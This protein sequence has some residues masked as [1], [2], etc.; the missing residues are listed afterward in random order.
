MNPSQFTIGKKI[1]LGFAALIALLAVVAGVSRYALAV[2]S[3]KFQLFSA[4]AAESHAAVSLETAMTAVKVQVN[5]FL[6]S[7]SPESIVAYSTAQKSLQD[8]ITQAEKVIVEPARARQI[9][10]AKELLGRYHRAFEALMENHARRTQLEETI[11]APKG[12]FVKDTLQELM[13]DARNQ[14]DM[15]AAFRIA[16]ALRAFFECGTQVSSFLSTSRPEMAT[17]ARASLAFVGKQIELLQQDQA[18]MEKLDA[19]LKDEAKT[20]RLAAL[21]AATAAYSSGL[22]QIVA[23]K[24]ARDELVRDG[25]N[26]IAPEFTA[27]IAQVSRSLHGYQQEIEEGVRA[28]QRRNELL[29]FGITLVGIVTGIGAGW[30]VVR[31]ATVPIRKIAVVLAGD[32]D[33]TKLAAASVAEAAH[34]MA[35]G[36]SQQAASLEESS[37]ALQE[38]SSM[39]N[40][41]S[42]SAQSA[43]QLAKEVRQTADAGAA[44]VELMKSSMRDIQ[45]SSAEI[46]KIIKTI[47]EIAFQTNILALNAAVE[48]AR[49]GEAGA[50]FAVVAEEVRSLAQRCAAA[51][52]ETGGKISDSTEKSTQGARMS[53]KVATNLSAIVERI[54]RLDEMVAE[55]AQASRE[56]SKGI[57]QVTEAVS[58]IDKITQSNAAL[59]QQSAT[60]AEEMKLQAEEVSRAVAELMSLVQD[61]AAAA[62]AASAPPAAPRA[63][64]NLPPVQRVVSPVVRN[65]HRKSAPLSLDHPRNGHKPVRGTDA[66]D[67]FEDTN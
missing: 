32:A 10:A 60:S 52:R 39:T 27:S 29:V 33:R 13:A 41:N 4:S 45:A 31:G 8:E 7:G 43:T 11:F 12:L 2:A 21:V 18:E 9:A 14:G 19:S 42:E 37:S 65:G 48:A 1:F 49:A 38:M 62:P 20:A 6:A 40:R 57:T 34:T 54:R 22:D 3:Q 16:N 67:F 30:V 58:G 46:S 55:I 50:G 5:D 15:N 23:A 44:D 26:K 28:S 17:A 47:D 53:E 64:V 25:I 51:A 35:D 63:A 59:S 36:A 56:Q 24:Q 61:G 66:S